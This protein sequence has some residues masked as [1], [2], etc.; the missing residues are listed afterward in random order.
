MTDPNPIFTQLAAERDLVI[1]DHDDEHAEPQP[2][3][4]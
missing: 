4:R 3:T 1:D 2:A